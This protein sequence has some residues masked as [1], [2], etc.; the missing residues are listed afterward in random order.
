MDR[1]SSILVKEAYETVKKYHEGQF[2][3]AGKPYFEHPLAVSGFASSVLEQ[4]LHH[5]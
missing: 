4:H 5:D 1:D 3:K 2:D